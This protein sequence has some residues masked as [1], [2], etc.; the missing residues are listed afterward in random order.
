MVNTIVP[1]K[2]EPWRGN[3]EL[4]AITGISVL[5]LHGIASLLSAEVSV[6]AYFTGCH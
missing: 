2:Q 3:G 5:L 1:Q 6:P 4:A